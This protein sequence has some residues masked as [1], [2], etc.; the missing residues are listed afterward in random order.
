MLWSQI[1]R[2]ESVKSHS[3]NQINAT[4]H[5]P[6]VFSHHSIVSQPSIKPVLQNVSNVSQPN[7]LQ[8]TSTI[9]IQTGHSS[10]KSYNSKTSN[11]TASSIHNRSTTSK[12]SVKS[13]IQKRANSAQA[14]LLAEQ[15]EAKYQRYLE[16]DT[17]ERKLK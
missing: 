2:S 7:K 11:R 14:Q 3:S 15:A 16:R 9:H 6:S 4:C 10:I 17:L 5:T 13:L 1:V 8:N 12:A